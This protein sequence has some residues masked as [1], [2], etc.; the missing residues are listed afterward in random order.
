MKVRLFALVAFVGLAA[1]AGVTAGGGYYSPRQYY[2]SWYH[3]PQHSYYYRDYYYKPSEDY[4]GYKHQ[5]VM[6]YPDHP[7]YCYYYNPYKKVYW[8]RC[9]LHGDGHE[10]YSELAESDRKGRWPTSRR[11]RSPRRAPCRRSPSPPT[12]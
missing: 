10:A 6:Y 12:R 11:R 4:T 9:P 1:T 3:S 8:G 7:D 5:Y 2:S